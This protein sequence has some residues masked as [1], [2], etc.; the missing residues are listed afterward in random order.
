[1]EEAWEL[2]VSH[3]FKSL[4]SNADLVVRQSLA[5]RDM[6]T[7]AERSSALEVVTRQR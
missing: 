6:N 5:S 3:C 1:V 4:S 2:E 7:E